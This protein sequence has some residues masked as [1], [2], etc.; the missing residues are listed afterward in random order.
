MK[1]LAVE[2][3]TEA[4][5]V[6]LSCQGEVASDHRVAPQQHA[7][8]VLPMISQLMANAEIKVGDLDAIAYGRGPGSFTGVRIGIALVQ[9]LA[10]GSETGV[11]GISTL[12]SVAQGCYRRSGDNRVAA[13]VDA[14]MQEVYFCAY[15]LGEQSLMKPLCDEVVCKPEDLLAHVSERELNDVFDGT[16]DMIWAGSGA[17][18]YIDQLGRRVDLSA[19]RVRPSCLPEAIDTLALAIPQI[20]QGLLHDPS[21]ANPVYLRDK[22]ALTTSE[23]ASQRS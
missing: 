21:E 20:R 12:Q 13:C 9:G 4:C 8:L 19:D 15:E 22:V 1:V 10:L 3:S 16:T 23:R 17:E 2:T 5:S 18:R 6:A 11:C 7:A 14:R